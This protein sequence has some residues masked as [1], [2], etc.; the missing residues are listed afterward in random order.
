[1]PEAA[2]LAPRWGRRGPV[3]VAST[4][5][6]GGIGLGLQATFSLDPRPAADADVLAG[7]R[8]RL[9]AALGLPGEPAWLRQV[10]G[11]EVVDAAGVEPGQR[12]EA[13]GAW[14]SLPGVVC[15]VLTADCLPVVLAD[16]DGR[17]VGLAHAGWRG[18]AAGVIESTVAA[19]PVA[20]ADLRAW[21][22][23][24]IGPRAFEVG[25]E[26]RAAFLDRDPGATGAFVAA[27]G[28]RWLGDLQALA[29]RRLQRLGV[30]EV[31]AAAG[32]TLSDPARFFSHR[33]DGAA[34]GRMATLAWIAPVH[35]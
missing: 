11:I 10:H 28:D 3:R 29:R 4:T 33:R 8:S 7:N 5:R 35:T 31:S 23:P 19:L 32:C 20:P 25:P 27:T 14:T 9:R 21:L 22:G 17:A 30:S 1:M 16:R 2:L 18:L 6:R 26:V 13:D 15:A 34:A 24:A 12:P